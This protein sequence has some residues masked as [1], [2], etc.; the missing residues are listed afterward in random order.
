MVAAYEDGTVSLFARTDTFFS[1]SVEGQGWTKLWNVKV[2]VESGTWF[3]L[4][5]TH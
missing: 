5:L 4:T 2:H 1:R 3:P